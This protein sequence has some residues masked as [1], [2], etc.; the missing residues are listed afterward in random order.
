MFDPQ[1]K[2]QVGNKSG[3]LIC[4]RFASHEKTWSGV[5]AKGRNI[6]TEEV[7]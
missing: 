2:V 6:D 7:I 4:N 3:I 1:A 5:G